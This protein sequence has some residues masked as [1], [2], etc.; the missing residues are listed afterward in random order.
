MPGIG[1]VSIANNLLSD[2]VQRNLDRNQAALRTSVERL[3]SGLRIASAADDPSGLAIAEKLQAQVS[4]FDQG[5]R[6]VQDASNA[7]TVADGALQ[8][9]TDILQRIRSLAVEASNDIASVNDKAHLQAEVAQ[10][11]QEVNRISLQ[12]QFNGVGLLDGSNAG[13]QPE[14]NA[15]LTITSNAVLA[16]AGTAGAL[17]NVTGTGGSTSAFT[18]GNFALP[19]VGAGSLN[20]IVPGWTLSNPPPDGVYSNNPPFAT[21]VSGQALVLQTNGDT[22]TQ[23]LTGLDPSGVYSITYQGAGAGGSGANA[24]V[25]VNGAGVGSGTFGGSFSATTTTAF[26]PDA[27]GTAV[28]SFANSGGVLSLANVT[29]NTISLGF[30]IGNIAT[31]AVVNSGLLIASAVAAN[32]NFNTAVGTAANG[33]ANVQ[34]YTAATATGGY[35]VDGT[36]ELQV[37]NTGASIAIQESFYNA[38]DTSGQP[39]SVAS[40]LLGANTLSILFDNVQI[41]TGNVTAADVG[42]TSYLKVSQNVAAQSSTSNPALSIHSGA[43]EGAAL[44]IGIAASN[45][46]T[47]RIANINLLLSAASSPSLGA[48]DAIGQIDNA[49]TRLLQERASLGATEVRLAED[50]DNDSIAATNVQSSE[51][52]IRDTNIGTETTTYARNQILVQTGTS[53]LAQSNANPRIV[54]TLFR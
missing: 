10:L 14:Q 36:I 5:S 48:E 25:S 22:V 21:P 11:L 20:H 2:A 29:L 28:V 8:T 23:T 27:T 13:F 19:N 3:S 45:T 37:I 52:Q 51:S 46:Q 16:S 44:A 26:T 41:A 40:Q 49:L 7:A 24:A 32:A 6:N 50:G 30:G 39:V 54:L 53:L 38:V 15:F 35:T 9:T 18:N 4:G 1:G 34:G 42:L 31:N 43:N 47:L 12:T 33:L 17:T